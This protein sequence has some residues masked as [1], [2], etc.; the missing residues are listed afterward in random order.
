MSDEWKDLPLDES[1]VTSRPDDVDAAY[2]GDYTA[3]EYALGRT[4]SAMG[5][6]AAIR[7]LEGD[8]SSA[9]EL[10]ES[11][12]AEIPPIFLRTILELLKGEARAP[13]TQER[14]AF[15]LKQLDGKK[16]APRKSSNFGTI[17]QK[18]EIGERMHKRYRHGDGDQKFISAVNDVATELRVSES[19]VHKAYRWYLSEMDK[20]I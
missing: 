7:L 4:G 2:W 16:G 13:A 15:T 5:V 11:H 14:V 1:I 20:R 19:H 17:I 18:L 8:F 6:I 9:I 12:E 10:L 3:G